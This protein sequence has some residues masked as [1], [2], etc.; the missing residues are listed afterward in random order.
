MSSV[1]V[2]EGLFVSWQPG[3]WVLR[4]INFSLAAGEVVGIIGSSGCGKSTLCLALAGIIPRQL[5]GQ[6]EGKIS[7]EGRDLAQF[8]LPQI[9][10]CLGIVFQDPETQLFLPRV[11][12]ELAF[13]PENLC[14][15]REEIAARI[16]RIAEEMGCRELLAANPNELSGGQQQLI[17]L[18]AVLALEPKV[19]ILDEVTAQLDPRTCQRL[20]AI[21]LDLR[22]RGMAVLM[23]EHNLQ[24]LACADR[25]L[26]LREGR[27]E[28]AAASDLDGEEGLSRVYGGGRV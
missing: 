5:P 11:R 12:N 17:A 22:Q 1:L 8:S 3:D 16:Q 7:L 10:G 14:L 19:L 18:A 27:M 23:A 13:G 21:V 4:D 9:A 2:A 25:I 15:P 6:V 20:Q 24:M 26:V 28:E